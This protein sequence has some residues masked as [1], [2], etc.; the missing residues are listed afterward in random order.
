[1]EIHVRSGDNFTF[2]T[3][4]LVFWGYAEQSD[5]SWPDFLKKVN[6]VRG[7]DRVYEGAGNI[8]EMFRL[9]MFQV[10]DESTTR[11]SFQC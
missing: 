4:V 5:I 7:V 3:S 10:Q 9:M 1:M 11:Q 8:V 2:Y 6:K